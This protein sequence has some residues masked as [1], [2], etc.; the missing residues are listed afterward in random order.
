MD[1]FTV[2]LL[3]IG[4]SM[5]AFAVSVCKG[6][7]MKKAD[8]KGMATCGAWFGAFQGL[9]PIIGFFIGKLFIDAIEAFDHWV[10]FGLLVTIGINMI[11]E[12]FSN[13]ELYQQNEQMQQRILSQALCPALPPSV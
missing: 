12:A 8:V 5:D 3:G 13:E 10:A 7:A 1:F 6:L 9:M 4:L 11:K 2:F